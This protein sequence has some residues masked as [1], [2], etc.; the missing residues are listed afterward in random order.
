[1][2][3]LNSE[4]RA[5]LRTIADG[6]L[7]LLSFCMGVLALFLIFWWD[8][9]LPNPFAEVSPTEFLQ[10]IALIAST[11]LYF[12][13]ALRRP[14][15]GRALVLVG[16]FL[17]C[18]LI[19]EQDYFLDPISHGC[20]KWPAIALAVACLAHALR[21]PAEAVAQLARFVRWRWFSVLLMGLV[22]VLAYSRLFGMGM[23]W[24]GMLSTECWH[25]AKTAMEESAEL[26]G[27]LLITFS[28][29]LQSWEF[30][31]RQSLTEC[32]G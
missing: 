27:Y 23:V 19:R 21:R 11:A 15:M 30:R 4:T 17:G 9:T 6:L 3:P 31:R 32:G 25:L 20:W 2:L 10:T 1:M 22:I 14:D 12:R 28:A 29:V 18:M 13:E 8:S 16:G 24:R 26:L 5:D 7:L